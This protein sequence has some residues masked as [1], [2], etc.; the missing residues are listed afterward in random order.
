MER[1][2][3][4]MNNFPLTPNLCNLDHCR[5]LIILIKRYAYDVSK[6]VK[7]KDKIDIPLY[8]TLNGHCTESSIPFLAVPS[9]T[10]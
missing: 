10:K 5:C 9:S 1:L 3:Q 4:Y 6:S 2:K 7:R 8:L